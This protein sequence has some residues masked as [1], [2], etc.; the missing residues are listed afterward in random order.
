MRKEGVVRAS[1]PCDLGKDHKL[2]GGK[3]I[4]SLIVSLIG[5]HA[6]KKVLSLKW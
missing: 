1:N 6:P 5:P 2:L 4:P 3:L